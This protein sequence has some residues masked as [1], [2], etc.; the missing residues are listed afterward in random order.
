MIAQKYRFHGHGS[1]RY[2]YRNGEIV[3]T[4]TLTI[5]YIKNPHRKQPR[6]VVI[7]AK[8][9]LKKAVRRNRMRRRMY[10]LLR[11]LHPQLPAN[12]DIAITVFSPELLLVSPK[13]LREQLTQAFTRAGLLDD[14]PKH[15]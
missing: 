5:R 3:R 10:E 2:L 12:Y 9:V 11:E 4:R 13:E 15:Q 1:L 7:V 14:S 6:F 8:K